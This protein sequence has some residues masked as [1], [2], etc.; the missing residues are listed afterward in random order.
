MCSAYSLIFNASFLK[1]N[2]TQHGRS[3]LQVEDMTVFSNKL[4]FGLGA[5]VHLCAPRGK[6][7]CA[8][9]KE[10]HQVLAK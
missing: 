3:R 4:G 5:C 1:F 6:K 9:P 7:K 10:A 2:S 8:L